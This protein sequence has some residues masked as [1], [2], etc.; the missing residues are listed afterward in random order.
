MTTPV[1]VSLDDFLAM[2]ETKPYLELVDGEVIPKA[3]PNADH[4][5]IVFELNRR[6]GNYLIESREGRGD[7]ELRN[8]ERGE[9]RVYLPDVSVTRKGRF[10]KDAHRGPVEVHPDLAIEV[11]S[12]DDRASRVAEKIDFYLRSGVSLVW[13]VDPELRTLTEYRPDSAPRTF[14]SG[15][16]VSAQPVLSAFT[17]DVAALFSVLDD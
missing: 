7:T 3:M 10:P 17:L 9:E 11:L 1:R 5:A 8:I 13:V 4:S 15:A 2:E 16:S 12:P 6:L 14:R